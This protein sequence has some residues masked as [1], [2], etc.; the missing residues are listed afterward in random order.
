MNRN[1]TAIAPTYITIKEIGKNS[2]SNNRSI[3]AVL[4]NVNTRNNTEKMGFLV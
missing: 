2:K 1:N 3:Q 4:K